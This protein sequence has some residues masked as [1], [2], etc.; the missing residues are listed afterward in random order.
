MPEKFKPNLVN[1]IVH[2]RWIKKEEY[3]TLL[4][5]GSDIKTADIQDIFYWFKSAGTNFFYV[6]EDTKYLC[7]SEEFLKECYNNKDF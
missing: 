2:R 7:G 3:Y 6:Y 5:A 1:L 4:P